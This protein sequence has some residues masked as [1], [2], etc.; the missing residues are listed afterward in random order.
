MRPCVRGGGGRDWNGFRPRPQAELGR[1]RAGAEP[2]APLDRI[3][4][5]T[6]VT[7][8]RTAARPPALDREVPVKLSAPPPPPPESPEPGPAP[9]PG[10]DGNAAGPAV[11]KAAATPAAW[12]AW[13]GGF[14]LVL[15]GLAVVL[16]FLLASFAARNSDVWLH[17]GAGRMLTTGE[18]ALGSDPLSYTAADRPW[19]NHSW[20]FDLVA[21]KLYSG[22]GFAL[23]LAKALVV[24]AALGLLVGVRRPGQPL[25]PWAAFAAVAALAAAPRLL[26]NPLVGSVFF[27]A[28]TLLLVFR[29]PSR[30]GSWRLP[31]AV[32]VTFWVWANVDAW[33]VLGPLA[34]G[35]LLVGDLVRKYALGGAAAPGDDDPL[36]PLPDT[37][38]LARA[39]LVGVVACML[40]PHHVRVWQIPFEL[41]GSDATT[42]DPSLR[43]LG[44]SPLGRAYW[45]DDRMGWSYSG[46]AYAALL[47]A[48]TYAAALAGAVGRVVGRPADIEPVPLP[49]ALLWGG[50]A[51]LSLASVFAIPFLAVVTVPL[52]ASRLNAISARVALTTRADRGT[53]L[54]LTGATAGRV[55]TLLVLAGLC[56]A[57]WP[58][59]LHPAVRNPAAV[60]RVAWQVEPDPALVRGAE[61]LQQWREA[62]DLPADARGLVASVDLA[63]YCAWYAP[64]EKVF[65]NGRFN[66][67]RPEL[68]DFVTVRAALHLYPQHEPPEP[69]TA[70][71]IMAARDASYVAIATVAGDGPETRAAVR[72]AETQLLAA[73]QRCSGWYLN[74]RVAVYGWRASEADT[75]PTF[76]R[77]RID[78]GRL[79]FGPGV[80]RVPPGAVTPVPQPRDWADEFRGPV[81]SG[82]ADSAEALA[83]LEYKRVMANQSKIKETFTRL[84]LLRA[85]PRP[86]PLPVL[87]DYF[88]ADSERTALAATGGEVGAPWPPRGATAAAPV[89]ALRAARRAVV[90]N[91]DHPDGYAALAEA[92]G[93][94]NLP[95]PEAERTLGVVTAFR[96]CL[97][98]M[99]PPSAY[100]REMVESS[101][102]QVALRLSDLYLGQPLPGGQFPGIRLDSG[103]VGGLVAG[104]VL[105]T[106]PGLRD[107]PRPQPPRVVRLPFAPQLFQQLP[108][109]AQIL[110]ARGRFV[111]LADLDRAGEGP[112]R[113][114]LALDLAQ[115]VLVRAGEYAAV[116][117][118]A[119]DAGNRERFFKGLDGRRKQV[120]KEL[121][122]AAEGYRAGAEKQPKVK[123]RYVF[124]RHTGLVGEAID[125]LKK[126]DLSK[127]FGPEAPRVAVEMAALELAAGR[128]E[129]ADADLAAIRAE[130][131]KLPPATPARPDEPRAILALLEYQ[132][133]LLAGDYAAA[134]AELEA[135]EGKGVMPAPPPAPD[136]SVPVDWAEVVPFDAISG[137]VAV[138]FR[139]RVREVRVFQIRQQIAAQLEREVSFFFRRGLLSLLEGDVEAAKARFR[140]TRR[141]PLPAWNLPAFANADAFEY[142]R[143][144]EAA[145]T[146]PAAP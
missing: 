68:G 29:L 18:Y 33:F 96:Q 119:G 79:A 99:P 98:R 62:G 132:K 127:E 39:L 121:Q 86:I 104:D 100:R 91:P 40:N 7:E 26:L 112:A 15:A 46:L 25:W 23:V 143:L 124:A 88:G 28:L 139:M 131:D 115:Q 19:V 73:W 145:E 45:D 103:V 130:F 126:A 49:H 5:T 3:K 4:I 141:P 24:A 20:L 136:V 14:D 144:I 134:G 81:R 8:F 77:L 109:E 113:F 67:H 57:A 70:R 32:G 80:E 30:P 97:S 108:K 51:I 102:T 44:Y 89:L 17:L 2:P 47:L 107:G 110:T 75:R 12:P 101:P 52:V 1:G 135:L 22:N 37:A 11:E 87:A 117:L 10:D 146:P 13:F 122:K 43:R 66:H 74:G 142:L 72:T 114:Y 53:R 38:T 63:N 6:S 16:G 125:M 85:V 138:A 31:A 35:L 123:D 133:S 105:V 118:T 48:G 36:G 128:L 55:A 50:F 34:L 90:A 61:Q 83:W 9:G 78:P 65:L 69:Q 116:E 95:L 41:L 42:A 111:P 59:W 27:L 94:P 129:D 140:A 56:V 84:L 54:A 58:G 120:E 60:R 137:P 21:F 106:L 93:D 76:D 82:A 64:G 71:D 92:L